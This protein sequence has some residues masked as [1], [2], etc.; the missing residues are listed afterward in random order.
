MVHRPTDL[1]LQLLLFDVA[2]DHNLLKHQGGT[3]QVAAVFGCALTV[4][5]LLALANQHC[6]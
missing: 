5:L 1:L 6:E 3:D 4:L 2:P